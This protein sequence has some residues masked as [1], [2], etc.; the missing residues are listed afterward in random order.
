M[1]T[2]RILVAIFLLIFSTS[3]FSQQLSA[4]LMMGNRNYWYQHTFSAPIGDSS[5]WQFFHTSSFNV[6]YEP[7]EFEVMSQSYAY[8]KLRKRWKIGLGTFFTPVGGFN[9]TIGA[10]YGIKTPRLLLVLSPRVDLRQSPNS[11]L[12]VLFEWK[13]KRTYFRFQL[14]ENVGL[15]GHNRSFQLIR[16]GWR[17]KHLTY[18]PS[19]NIDYYGNRFT[20]YLN[21]GIFL[22]IESMS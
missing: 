12:M 1:K 20:T 16:M 9:P 10:Q 13:S 11:E 8:F 5:N 6:F 3:V 19:L 21:A 18:G 14:M 22:R 7:D 2:P 4:E 15:K 17:S